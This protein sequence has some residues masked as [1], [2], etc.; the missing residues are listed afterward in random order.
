MKRLLVILLTSLVLLA[1]PVMLAGGCGHK[2]EVEPLQVGSLELPFTEILPTGENLCIDLFLGAYR[3][4]EGTTYLSDGSIL[5]SRFIGNEDA[6]TVP[7]KNKELS[8]VFLSMCIY[9]YQ[10]GG[11]AIERIHK[12]KESRLYKKVG[13]T[14]YY[15]KVFGFPTE[16]IAG[17]VSFWK[18]PAV[19]EVQGQEVIF[20]RVG[21]YVGRYTV[22]MHDPPEL[23]DGYFMPPEL[24]D[25]LYS[26]IKK[27]IPKLR[28]LSHA[29]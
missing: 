10:N 24:H 7:H 16:E 14:E 28:S 25:L 15:A 20:F 18:E 2:T 22:H 21:R 26:A 13:D 17:Y 8:P 29:K 5:H 6:F 12:E 3:T 4:S 1:A 9:V 27:T 19:Q 11:Q 23:E